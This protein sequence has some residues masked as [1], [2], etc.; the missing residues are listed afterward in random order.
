ME[1]VF[2]KVDLVEAGEH[3]TDAELI[4]ATTYSHNAKQ[5]NDG[6][7]EKKNEIMTQITTTNTRDTDTEKMIH[8]E[9]TPHGAA[10]EIIRGGDWHGD[11]AHD[12]VFS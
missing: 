4:E 12:G 3:D 9:K 1:K 6:N 8:K 7:N 10:Q 11:D 2:G 5:E